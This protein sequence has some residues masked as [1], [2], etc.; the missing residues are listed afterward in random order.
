M[1]PKSYTILIL[2]RG[3]SRF[4]KL[5]VS[6][7]ATAVVGVLAVLALGLA[8]VVPSLVWR[9]QAQEGRVEQLQAENAALRAEKQG[10][11]DAIGDLSNRLDQSEGRVVELA[12]ELGV[13]P[14][15]EPAAGGAVEGGLE[16]SV[17]DQEVASLGS[18]AAALDE[19]LAELDR[20]YERRLRILASTPNTM[21]VEGW[22]SHGFGWR[23]DPWTGEREF[24]R[25]IDIVT[26]S[27]TPIRAPGDGVVSRTARLSDYGKTI[28]LSHGSG[29]VTRYA[30]LSEVLVKTG[31]RVRRGDIIGRVGSTGRSTGAHLHYEVFR[32]GRRVNPWKY[33]GQR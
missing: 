32:D 26:D 22:F 18:R 23:K 17:I 20:V 1:P 15:G 6:T 25:G 30:H 10:W 27:G 5:R 21:P 2:A 3:S 29:Y 9:S 8:L 14:P 16:L 13:E 31:Q 19:S 24:H 4:R 12:R 33:L 28:D 11:E 7:R